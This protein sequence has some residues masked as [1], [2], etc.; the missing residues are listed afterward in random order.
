MMQY[1]AFRAE[2]GPFSQA[3]QC[4][5]HAFESIDVAEYA[6]ATQEI[7]YRFGRDMVSEQ[8]HSKIVAKVGGVFE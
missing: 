6:F 2:L 4:D 5:Q 8:F 7:R 1:C 3:I